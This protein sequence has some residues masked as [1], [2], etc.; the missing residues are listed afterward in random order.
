MSIKWPNWKRASSTF[1]G[2][3]DAMSPSLR[4]NMCCT[5]PHHVFGTN[6]PS[7]PGPY[8]ERWDRRGKSREQ[9]QG[10]LGLPSNRLAFWMHK[11]GGRNNVFSSI[12]LIDKFWW[13]F[14]PWV[15]HVASVD[16]C[17]VPKTFGFGAL[18]PFKLIWKMK[19]SLN[20]HYSGL[21]Q[22]G[23]LDILYKSNSNLTIWWH[24]SSYALS[25]YMKRR[26]YCYAKREPEK[27]QYVRYFW[28]KCGWWW[29]HQSEWFTLSAKH[30]IQPY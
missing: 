8:R 1:L 30:Y 28:N 14:G 15:D 5:S 3:V 18:H 20:S 27:H 6:C 7:T 23:L 26:N 2:L 19:Q 25:I 16:P 11:C 21:P 29:C 17:H 9:A 4:R 24:T 10:I 12:V 22:V 13:P